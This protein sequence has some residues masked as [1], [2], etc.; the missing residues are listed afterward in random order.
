MIRWN[1]NRTFGT[2]NL[3]AVR[4]L[5]ADPRRCKVADGKK[6]VTEPA[7]GQ[8]YRFGSDRNPVC[9]SSVDYV[10]QT[11]NFVRIPDSLARSLFSGDFQYQSGKILVPKRR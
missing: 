7:A 4:R 8:I 2:A 1:A 6:R 11:V 3:D 10:R 9:V 5:L